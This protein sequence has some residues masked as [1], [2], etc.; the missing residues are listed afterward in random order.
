MTSR[1]IVSPAEA[2]AFILGGNAR[3]TLVSKATGARYTYRVRL[4]KDKKIYFVRLLTGPDNDS[5][6]EYLGFIRGG[7]M[8]MSPKSKLKAESK[9]VAAFVWALQHLGAS[10]LPAAL[11]IWHD[12][13]C[14]RC[15][16][17]L[18]VPSS[19][20]SGFGPECVKHGKS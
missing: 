5:H 18:T 3:F 17:S 14:G 13:H 1:P 4:S 20:A 19:L 9:P 15:G 2:L 11:E 16:R 12:G 6:Y 7:V 10:S 8:L